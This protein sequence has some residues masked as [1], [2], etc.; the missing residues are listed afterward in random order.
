MYKLQTI[1]AGL[2]AFLGFVQYYGRFYRNLFTIRSSMN[3]LL[4]K[5]V[6]WKWTHECQCAYEACKHGISEGSCFMDCDVG[7]EMISL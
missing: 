5:N 4:R 6:A 1:I 3:A 2:Q 7:N